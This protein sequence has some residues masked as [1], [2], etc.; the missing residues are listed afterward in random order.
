MSEEKTCTFCV[1]EAKRWRRSGRPPLAARCRR[2]DHPSAGIRGPISTHKA[3]ST[4]NTEE[5]M[6]ALNRRTLSA[7]AVIAALSAPATSSAMINGDP[8]APTAA[9]R[10]SQGEPSWQQMEP[11]HTSGRSRNRSG[12]RPAV[13]GPGVRGSRRT[14]A[15]PRGFLLKEGSSGTTPGSA[16]PESSRCSASAPGPSPR[17]PAAAPTRARQLTP[18][19]RP[20][21]THARVQK[22]TERPSGG[23]PLQPLLRDNPTQ[24]GDSAP[25]CQR[26]A[27]RSPSRN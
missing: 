12:R 23:W 2:S 13:R 27:R 10:Q 21:V 14:S 22:P 1:Y 11:R 8:G 7:A 5:H 25:L 4:Q 15:A 19:V 17:S 24:H 3:I 20:R 9:Q 18:A 6:F 16:P 26:P